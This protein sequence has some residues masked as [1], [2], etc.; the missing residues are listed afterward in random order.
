MSLPRGWEVEPF[1]EPVPVVPQA[2]FFER[3]GEFLR[4]VEVPH[5]RN[6]LLERAEEAL[7]TAVTFGLACEGR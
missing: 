4:R 6:P 7:D 1:D 2:E 3:F 5:P